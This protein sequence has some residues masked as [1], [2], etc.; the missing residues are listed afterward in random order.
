MIMFLVD[1]QSDRQADHK[2]LSGIVHFSDLTQIL[3]VKRIR[4]QSE[5]ENQ[6]RE[7]QIV[8]TVVSSLSGEFPRKSAIFVIR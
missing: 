2:Q 6:D 1:D 7:R 3:F 8:R 4:F 5:E